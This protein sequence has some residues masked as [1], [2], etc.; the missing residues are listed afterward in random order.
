[1]STS[2]SS[3]AICAN[4]VAMPCPSSTLPTAIDTVPSDSR[5]TRCGSFSGLFTRR[6]LDSLDHAAVG[7][8][9]A[10]VLVEGFSNFAFSRLLVFLQKSRS[11]DGDAAHAEAALCRLF[12][13]QC[14]LHAA[15]EPFHSRN[16]LSFCKGHRQIAGSHRAAVD[17]HV[18]RAALTAAA[19]EAAADQA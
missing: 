2:S 4:A 11:A 13:Q 10:Q 19:A 7:A 16:L 1:M 9:T 17:Q 12:R 18:A 14:L 15:V 6:P 5:R 8:A 3:A